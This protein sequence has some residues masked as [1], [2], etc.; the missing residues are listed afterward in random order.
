MDRTICANLLESSK[1]IMNYTAES[2]MQVRND[3]DERGKSKHP[4]AIQRYP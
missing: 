3:N 4:K 2:L 1:N